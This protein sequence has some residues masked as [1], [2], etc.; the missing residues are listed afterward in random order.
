MVFGGV[1]KRETH[2]LTLWV[3]LCTN[4]RRR[5]AQGSIRVM[6]SI[7][8][9]EDNYCYPRNRSISAKALASSAS[10]FSAR[11]LTFFISSAGV[12]N[13]CELFGL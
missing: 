13:H 3:L 6:R 11:V 2:K 9:T 8:N 1:E 10:A 12:S 5:H 4:C 7:F